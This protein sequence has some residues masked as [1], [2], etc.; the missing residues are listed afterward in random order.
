M[1]WITEELWFDS[2]KE[3]RDFPVLHNIQTDSVEHPASNPMDNSD[4][5]NSVEF[6]LFQKSIFGDTASRYRTSK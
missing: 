4:A 6:I 5:F 2:H 3:E 1:G